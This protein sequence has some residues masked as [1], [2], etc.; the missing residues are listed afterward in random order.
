VCQFKHDDFRPGALHGKALPARHHGVKTQGRVITKHGIIPT[1]LP[2]SLRVS[3][4]NE[5]T[6]K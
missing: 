4:S 3:V 6:A 2:G 5:K 1:S